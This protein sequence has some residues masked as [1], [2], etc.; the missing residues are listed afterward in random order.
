VAPIPAKRRIWRQDLLDALRRMA[1]DCLACDSDGLDR[2]FTAEA[3]E[4][5]RQFVRQA[6]AFAPA[7][8]TR[9]CSRPCATSGQS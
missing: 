4:A 5:T 1:R 8:T 2:L 9:V 6:R 3:L 7:I